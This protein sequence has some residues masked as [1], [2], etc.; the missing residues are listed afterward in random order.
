MS[1]FYNSAWRRPKDLAGITE[2]PVSTLDGWPTAAESRSFGRTQV[3][4]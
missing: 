1:C 3:V 2:G 4:A